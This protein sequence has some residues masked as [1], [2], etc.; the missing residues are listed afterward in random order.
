MPSGQS[1]KKAE[2]QAALYEKNTGLRLSS[3][4]PAAEGGGAGAAGGDPA[5]PTE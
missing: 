2:E 1:R 4:N 3:R 5:K